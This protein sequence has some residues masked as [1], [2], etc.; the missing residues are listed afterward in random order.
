MKSTAEPE[1]SDA[2]I[3]PDN[4]FYGYKKNVATL[5]EEREVS[6]PGLLLRHAPWQFDWLKCFGFLFLNSAVVRNYNWQSAGVDPVQHR[7]GRVLQHSGSAQTGV[8]MAFAESGKRDTTTQIG[9]KRVEDIKTAQK[10]PVGTVRNRAYVALW[11]CCVVDVL[12]FWSVQ[13]EFVSVSV[14]VQSFVW[15][16]CLC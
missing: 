11:F 8:Q 9:P 4:K 6:K 15:I 7:F 2:V 12:W 14:C 10:H 1:P 5:S 3:Q 16:G 13:I